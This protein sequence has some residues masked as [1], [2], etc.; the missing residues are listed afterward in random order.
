MDTG[1]VL[2]LQATAGTLMLSMRMWFQSLA[3]FSG[4]RIQQCRDL[5]CRSQMWLG[6]GVALAVVVAPSLGTSLCCGV[7]LKKTKKVKFNVI[8]FL[9]VSGPQLCIGKYPG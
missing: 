8:L 4:L 2:N 6:S 1:Q 3:P 9:F 7:A 5:C